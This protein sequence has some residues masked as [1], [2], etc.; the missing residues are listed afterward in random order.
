MQG[1]FTGN[2][3]CN[4]TGTECPSAELVLAFYSKWA[5]FSLES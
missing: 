1:F 4:R 3:D 2:E 5:L